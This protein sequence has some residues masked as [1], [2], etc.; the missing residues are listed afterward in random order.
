MRQDASPSHHWARD[1]HSDQ[2]RLSQHTCGALIQ[3]LRR[4][5]ETLTAL[6]SLELPL[7]NF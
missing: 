3:A 7:Q 6:L 1:P 5:M 2:E 4:L